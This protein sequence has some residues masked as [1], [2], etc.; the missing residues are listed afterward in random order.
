MAAGLAPV[1]LET[2]VHHL[3]AAPDANVVVAQFPFIAILL[4]L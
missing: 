4:Y 2:N 3:A 1:D